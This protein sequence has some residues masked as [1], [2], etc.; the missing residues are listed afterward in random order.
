MSKKPKFCIITTQRSGSTWL[1]Q[2]LNSHHQIKVLAGDPFWDRS[3]PFD[4]DLP[5]Y[6]DFRRNSKVSRPRVAFDYLNTLDLQTYKS[7]PHDILGFKLMYNHIKHNP[8]V[9]IKLLI[10]KY[11]I[12]HLSRRNVL[13]ILISNTVSKQHGVYHVKKSD[14]KRKSAYLD[15]DLLLPTLNLYER[16]YQFARLF[17]KAIP[18]PVLEVRYETLTA[19][20]DN[21]LRLIAD[22][23]QVDSSS[24][25]FESSLKKAN[26]GSYQDKIANYSEVKN[27][28]DKSKYAA[29]IAN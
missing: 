24:V 14:N 17:L 10:D 18:L 12:I 3:G 21:I 27:I 4:G 29:L 6:H 23:L 22:F 8:E 15:P 2:L 9:L 1:T 13:D 26:A 7:E 25:S 20:R 5:R 16:S 11:R 28:L 19:N